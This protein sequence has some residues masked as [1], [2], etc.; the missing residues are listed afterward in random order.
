MHHGVHVVVGL[1]RI[2]GSF[3]V[4]RSLW[5]IRSAHK[6]EGCKQCEYWSTWCVGKWNLLTCCNDSRVL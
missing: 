3:S 6:R 1:R 2:C 4:M 5:V